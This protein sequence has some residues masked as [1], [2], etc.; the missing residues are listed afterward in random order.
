[1]KDCEGALPSLEFEGELVKIGLTGHL[2]RRAFAGSS[3]CMLGLALKGQ[4]YA[5]ESWHLPLVEEL[6]AERMVEAAQLRGLAKITRLGSSAGGRLIDMISV[7]E[8]RRAALIVGAPHANEPIGCLTIQRLLKR[9]GSDPHLRDHS[10]Y[11]WHLI[12][13][14]DNDGNA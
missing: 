4:A 11:R 2:S 10:G 14:I 3:L 7:G 5:E 1:L 8:G 9:L 13:A 6:E 12:P